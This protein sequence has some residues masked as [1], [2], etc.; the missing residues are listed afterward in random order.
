MKSHYRKLAFALTINGIVMYFVMYTM[1]DTLGHFHF[2]INQLYM[3]LMMVAP[4][5]I[6]MILVMR[7]MFENEKLNYLLLGA[8]AV[9]F[10]ASVLFMR[11]QFAVGNT[12]F[13]R[14]M[15]PHHSGAILMCERSAITDPEIS[16][17]CDQIIKSQ[18]EEIAQMERILARY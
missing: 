13:L 5:L 10:V 7:A 3:T 2:N 9:V 6:V 14:A 16:V 4:M 12:E 15:I 8:S 18:K 11:T 17:L 1:I